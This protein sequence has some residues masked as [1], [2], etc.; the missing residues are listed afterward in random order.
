MKL[1]IKSL[2]ICLLAISLSSLLGACE[3]TPQVMAEQRQF[4]DVKLEFLDEYQLEKQDF[5]NTTVGGLSAIA[6]NRQRDRFYVL[7]DDRSEKAPAR[8]Y[9]LKIDLKSENPDKTT[10]N[11]ITLEKVTTLKNQNGELFPRQTLDPE[12]IALSPRGTVFISSEGAVKQGIN[13]FIKEFNLETGQEIRDLTLPQRYLLN[14]TDSNITPQGIQDNFGFEALTLNPNSL[15]PED[16][17]RLFTA[18][19]SSLT[20]DFD[21]EQPPASFPLRFLH[22]VINPIGNPIIVAEH[23]YL[24]EPGAS[25]VITNG[26]TELLALP[27]EGYFLSLERTYGLRGAGA[28]IFQVI[29]ANATD[30]SNIA[31]LKGDTSQIIPMTKKLLLDLSELGIYLDNLEGM[32]LG[33]RLS[34]GSQ[35]LILV[36]DDNFKN[37]QITQFLLFRI[38]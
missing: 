21:P 19:E 22:Y 2:I 18:V 20:Q 25:D 9:T 28:K 11:K 26:L 35:S 14:A 15:A 4:M 1:S 30:T 23:L 5:E 36:S 13:P 10:I 17:F 27:T 6:Y 32:T 3:A 33:P 16:P 24:L 29:I 31:S 8:F 7:S 34:D 37:D 38:K 12:G